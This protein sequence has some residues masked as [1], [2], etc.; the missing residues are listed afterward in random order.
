M[1]T[2]LQVYPFAGACGFAWRADS[3]GLISKVSRD[4]PRVL[5]NMVKAGDFER[6][7]EY[8]YRDIMALGDLQESTWKIVKLL[9]WEEDFTALLERENAKLWKTR[10]KLIKG[11]S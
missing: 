7:P 6:D 4:T 3:L 9:G 5:M 11:N 1:G 10:L 2:S 8:N